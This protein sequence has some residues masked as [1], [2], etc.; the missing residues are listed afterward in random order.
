MANTYLVPFTEV[1]TVKVE[2]FAKV[3]A[4]SPKEAYGKLQT[5]IENNGNPHCCADEVE[6][7]FYDGKTRTVQ[8]D[9]ESVKGDIVAHLDSLSDPEYSIDE[10]NVDDVDVFQK[11]ISLEDLIKEEGKENL[12]YFMGD[13][14]VKVEFVDRMNITKVM[15]QIQKTPSK[16]NDKIALSLGYSS[17]P[18]AYR[19]FGGIRRVLEFVN[20]FSVLMEIDF[21]KTVSQD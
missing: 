6:H 1:E 16:W 2:Y 15:I 19:N 20:N 12:Y 3:C 7:T 11:T 5:L 8:Y 13:G 4:N 10:Y 17:N 14:I 9:I 21:S 18:L